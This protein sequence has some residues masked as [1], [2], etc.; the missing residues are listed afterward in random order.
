MD[1]PSGAEPQRQAPA[2]PL[3]P[4]PPLPADSHPHPRY[5]EP[6]DVDGLYFPDAPVED[7]LSL[8]GMRLT[9]FPDVRSNAVAELEVSDNAIAQ[10][11][12]LPPGLRTLRAQVRS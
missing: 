2:R 12:H 11:G 3:H 7:I 5:V 6:V 10:A 9:A 8:S 1:E 4:P